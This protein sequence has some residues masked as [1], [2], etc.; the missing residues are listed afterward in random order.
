MDV[1]LCSVHAPFP[2]LCV[3]LV[4]TICSFESDSFDIFIYILV[5]NISLNMH[6]TMIKLNTT[7]CAVC[8]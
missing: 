4:K 1:S 2:N 3:V 7:L 8:T 6:V 5:G